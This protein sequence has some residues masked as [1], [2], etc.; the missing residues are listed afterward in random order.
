MDASVP[1]FDQ[2]LGP[3][4]LDIPPAGETSFEEL[5]ELYRQRLTEGEE[6]IHINCM[7]TM[8][9]CRAAI[10]AVQ[11]AKRPFWVS[12]AFDEDGES[13]TRVHMLAALFVAEGMGAA[14]FGLNCRPVLAEEL[15]EE[16]VPYASIPLFSYYDEEYTVW[17]YEVREKDPDMIPCATGIEPCFISRLVDVGEEIECTPDLLEDIIAA[18]DDPV[19]AVKIA[20]Q[21]PD[22]VDIFAENQYAI[23]EA[24]CLWSDV[25]ELLEG[26]LRAFQGRAFYDGTG[27]LEEED[28]APLV[29]KYGLIVL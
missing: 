17:P 9:E 23:R 7:T 12:W 21:E 2:M 18:E 22:D 19:G 5:V 25:P 4:G 29:K 15:M 14:A 13:F 6:T 16:L 10:L 1:I 24:L 26:A 28:L 27:D 8:A 11:E 3:L 20:I